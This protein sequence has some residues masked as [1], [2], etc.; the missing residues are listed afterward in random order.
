MLSGTDERPVR[1]IA[2]SY[3]GQCGVETR[4]TAKMV[5]VELDYGPTVQLMQCSVRR[6]I[7]ERATEPPTEIPEGLSTERGFELVALFESLEAR[8]RV[9]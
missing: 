9:S 7:V 5:Y 8:K 3:R 4:G 1:V 2:G 6:V